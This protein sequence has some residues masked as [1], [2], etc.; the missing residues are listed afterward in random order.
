[1]SKRFFHYPISGDRAAHAARG[2]GPAT[3]YETPTGT[4]IDAPFAGVLARRNTRDGGYGLTL[5]GEKYI[6][7]AQHLKENVKPGRVA[8]RSDIAVSGNTG[9]TTG[10]HVHA[11]ILIRATG[12]RI[13]FQE[14]LD[15]YVNGPA[16]APAVA[17]GK[18]TKSLVGRKLELTSQ[19]WYRTS[20]DADKLR[21][22]KGGKYGGGIMLSGPY[23]ILAVAA[24]G[25]LKVLSN[26]NGYV[27]IHES[28]VKR[29]K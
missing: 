23:T 7:V 3:D 8:W 4:I 16:S 28:A 1:M 13:S 17:A 15:R 21:N 18:P 6:F 12:E 5:T 2:V 11:W 9:A 20:A 24:N 19:Y 26:A 22:P 14:W 27:W 10:P 29:L 25:S